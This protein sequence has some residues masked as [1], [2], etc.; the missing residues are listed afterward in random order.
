M[1]A[2][3]AVAGLLVAVISVLSGVQFALRPTGDSETLLLLN[4]LQASIAFAVV[5]SVRGRLRR[6]PAEVA[7]GF[8]LV[9]PVVPLATLQLRP[10]SVVLASASLALIPIGVAL[11]IPWSHRMHVAW[12]SGFVAIVA[13]AS[14]LAAPYLSGPSEAWY[15]LAAVGIGVA[16]GILGQRRRDRQD[17]MSYGREQTL[18]KLIEQSATQQAAL[19][20]LN[21]ELDRVLVREVQGRE[22]IEA[23]LA[24][25]DP[26]AGPEEIAATACSEIIK[27]PTIDAAW[28]IAL[29][30]TGGQVLAGAGQPVSHPEMP[31]VWSRRLLDR[32]AAGPWA[33]SS[34]PPLAP[35]PDDTMRNGLVGSI[36]SPLRGA[37]G[38]VIG[39]IGCG[40]HDPVHSDHVAE[41]LP[42]I[43]TYGSIV[44]ALVAPGLE[45]RL[46]T[47]GARGRIR[48]VLDSGAFTP[49]YQPIVELH[50]GKVVG[51]EALTRFTDGTRPDVAFNLARQSGLGIELELATLRA[52]V[53]GASVLPPAAY[54]GLN[55]SPQALQSVDLASILQRLERV[56]VL[57]ITE[58]DAIDDYA[59]VLAKIAALGPRVRLA[60]DDAGA[61]YASLR[62]ILELS[63][64]IVKLDI[65]LVRGID[66]DPAR[67]ALIAGVGYF[68]VK[69][70]MRLVAEGIETPAEL[71]TLRSLGIGFGQGYL[72]GRPQDGRGPGPWVD[73]IMTPDG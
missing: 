6:Y 46:A 26:G 68:A 59:V 30:A 56:V 31:A 55:A 48:A 69:R 41:L 72:L 37:N 42:A 49:F 24:S 62:H 7:F 70:K 22:S 52:A 40:T 61:G 43:T 14:Y 19:E 54:V 28:A 33:E 29:D 18:R 12:S 53:E 60:V 57:E 5:L 10:E 58:H 47:R 9:V 4:A 73:R 44:G 15:L 51:Y 25:I 50:S 64:D 11:F 65:G 32:A 45:A 67:Q 17:R 27:L 34:A 39:V 2:A 8:L 66:A 35:W 1:R 3:L 38:V 13:V 16:F 20:R 63:P 71:S 36:W 23:A 21:A